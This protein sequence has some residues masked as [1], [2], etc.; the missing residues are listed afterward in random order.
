MTLEFPEW[1]ISPDLIDYE[2]ALAF[3]EE[4][5]HRIFE[6][7]DPECVWLLEHPSLYTGGTSA[8]EADLLDPKRFPV[9]KTGRG[10]EYTYHGPG[11][12]I[13]YVMLNLLERAA[14][15]GEEPDL[16]EYV[17]NLEGWIIMVLKRFGVDGERRQGRVGIWVKHA[18]GK[19]EKIAAIGI[20]VRKWVTFHGVAL[21]VHPDL[22]HFGGIV[23]CGIQGYGVTSLKALG[24]DVS[25][26]EVDAVLKEEFSR[27]FDR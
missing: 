13:A 15:K 20:R 7:R 14:A 27:A 18:N 24:V 25:L 8:K 2:E 4:R 17:R 10:G 1:K 16:R 3:M 12:R 6:K 19:E 26:E 21:N 23:P 5:A 11:M 9:Y 22:S